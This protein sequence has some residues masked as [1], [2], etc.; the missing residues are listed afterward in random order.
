[1]LGY[2]ETLSPFSKYWGLGAV[3]VLAQVLQRVWVLNCVCYGEMRGEILA[4]LY[5]SLSLGVK[6]FDRQ[7]GDVA[8]TGQMY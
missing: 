8:S 2:W 6:A 3:N 1:M 5:P 4:D 7:S